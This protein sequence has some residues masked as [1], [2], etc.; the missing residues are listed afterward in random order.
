MIVTFKIFRFDSKKDKIP[1]FDTFQIET[2]LNEK[3]LDCLNKIR[4]KHDSSLSYRMGCAHGICGSD[5][6]I[7]NGKPT[8]ACQRLIKDFN[9]ELPIIIE[10]LK[11]FPVI[12]DL[13][14]NIEPFFNK[15]KKVNIHKKTVKIEKL[16]SSETIQ[17]IEEL[18]SFKE[19]VRCIL[20]CCCVS[21]CPINLE[22]QPE[23][24]GPAALLRAYKYIFDSRKEDITEFIK[25][26]EKPNGIWSCKSHYKCTIVCP[27][28]I[29]VTKNILKT[30]RKLRQKKK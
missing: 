13:V 18:D 26:L 30:K 10:P 5:G 8:L 4:A 15:I 1:Y 20:C 16:K 14:I 19:A 11:F 2:G 7:I 22:E 24:I 28:Q 9:Y 6:M 27:K 12:K 3:I 29:K 23:F 21:A 25:S 17:S